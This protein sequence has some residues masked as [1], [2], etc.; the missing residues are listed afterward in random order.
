[1]AKLLGYLPLAWIPSP[2]R[3]PFRRESTETDAALAPTLHHIAVTNLTE[4]LFA[5][6][7]AGC[8]SPMGEPLAIGVLVTMVPLSRWSAVVV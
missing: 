8:P 2:L 6:A 3:E 1:M 5:Q 7:R 4:L